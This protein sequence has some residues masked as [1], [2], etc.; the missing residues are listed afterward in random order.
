MFVWESLCW[1][2]I[3]IWGPNFVLYEGSFKKGLGQWGRSIGL[4]P[5]A[6]MSLG[7]SVLYISPPLIHTW[8]SGRI[9]EL[10]EPFDLGGFWAW[11]SWLWLLINAHLKRR[12]VSRR[13]IQLSL[14]SDGSWIEATCVSVG[15]GIRK[16]VRKSCPFVAWLNV[17]FPPVFDSINSF[18]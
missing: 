15:F 10:A 1:T 18:P 3:R 14:L 4:G 12:A 2:H 13:Q 6:H 16:A 17:S 5:R 7:I 11:D 9:K 8:L